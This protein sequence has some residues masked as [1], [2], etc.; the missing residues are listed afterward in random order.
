M[1]TQRPQINPL[2][3]AELIES[4]P[5][6]VR[7]R[8]DA[9]PQVAHQ[10]EW[11]FTED[12]WLITAGEET[13]ELRSENG[14]IRAHEHLQC[15]CLLTPKCFHVVACASILVPAANSGDEDGTD[16]HDGESTSPG[17]AAPDPQITI[18]DA[19]RL[20]ARMAQASVGAVLRVGASHSGL[21]VQSS[22]L[23]AAH[24][25]RECGLVAL[26]N[27]LLRI[28]E[29]SGRLRAN[30]DTAD[31]SV[32]ADDLTEALA[33]SFAVI[34]QS[35]V[36]KWLIGETRRTFEPI[37]VR[38][39]VGLCAEPIMTL[40]GYAGVCVYLQGC[41]ACEEELFTINELRPGGYQLVLQAYGGGIDLGTVAVEAK[42]LCRCLLTVQN[43]QTSGDGRLGKGKA[44]RWAVQSARHSG[45]RFRSGRFALTLGEQIQGVFERSLLSPL[46]RR[47]GWDLVAFDAVIVGPSGAGVLVDVG[48]V[49]IPWRLTIAV[50][51]T[52][53]PYRE[54]LALLAR[55]PGL[56]LRCV[57]RPKL[58]AAGDVDLIAISPT[59]S[60]MGDDDPSGERPAA[61]FPSPWQDVCNVGLDRLERHHF[62]GIQRWSD[63]VN[64]SDRILGH[65]P[66]TDGLD[67]L[68]RR[69]D[70]LAL[71]GR[72]AVPAVGSG[73]HRREQRRLQQSYQTTASSLLEVLAIAASQAG[74]NPG[75]GRGDVSQ[76]PCTLED[77]Y[78]A[79]ASYL[80]AARVHF[81][82]RA[83]LRCFSS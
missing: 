57:G 12:R 1:S 79:C 75:R 68:R 56:S 18:T 45:D 74:D 26:G 48:Q 36:P 35:S 23:R 9:D 81:E 72:V 34:K 20:A 70:G 67:S 47:G 37:D 3:L 52:Q 14:V 69:L 62:R 38:K 42:Q 78:L 25:C 4:M 50:D 71:G 39:L 80:Q 44:T 33:A 22:V 76:K 19:M 13:V 73:A 21:L 10:W 7:K 51:D 49:N 17:L 55:C 2:F 16:E 8:L 60:K 30:R 11:S 24:Q 65:R 32:L 27:A 41:G 83:W 59:E 58:E 5:G 53:L 28:V 43:L 31:A 77:A 15:S 29:G 6:R 63:E 64:L 61:L 46:Q 40:S 54:N 82:S 66:P